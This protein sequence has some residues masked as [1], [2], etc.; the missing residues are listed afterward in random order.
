[1]L[2]HSNWGKSTTM[3][4]ISTKRSIYWSSIVYPESA[5]MQIKDIKEYFNQRSI[6]FFLS[7]LH[8]NDKDDE[9]QLK[10]P[11][12]HLLLKFSS[13]K[14]HLQVQLILSYITEVEPIIISNYKMYGRY[15]THMD[16]PEKAQYN[17]DDVITNLDYN[18]FLDK[19]KRQLGLRKIFEK[20]LDGQGISQMISECLKNE[21]FDGIELIRQNIHLLRTIG[22]EQFSM[23]MHN[24]EHEARKQNEQTITQ[25]RS[26]N[27][28][29]I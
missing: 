17:K 14:S 25:Q 23:F 10:K 21:D 20:I 5:K 1:M 4:R 9:G 16:N 22:Q 27:H 3:S 6:G 8:N 26:S 28:A 29:N 24:K 18:E 2:H 15:L 13:L 19:E 11:H 12:Y 7:P